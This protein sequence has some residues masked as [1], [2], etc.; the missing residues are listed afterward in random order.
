MSEY[1]WKEDKNLHETLRMSPFLQSWKPISNY[2]APQPIRELMKTAKTYNVTLGCAMPSK[3][4]R[5]Q[6]PIWN[7]IEADPQIWRLRYSGEAKCLQNNHKAQIV[8]ETAKLAKARLNPLH[9]PNPNCMCE[10]CQRAGDE[11]NCEF[12][13]LCY[14]KAEELLS[15]IPEKWTPDHKIP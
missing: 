1:I 6:M 5:N 10:D 4:A 2:K 12:P 8:S 7:H 14:L 15:K 9:V 3:Q 11:E 13:H